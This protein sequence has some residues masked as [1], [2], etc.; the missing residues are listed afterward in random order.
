MQSD[1]TNSESGQP[2]ISHM[3]RFPE[4]LRAFLL[5]HAA[6]AAFIFCL[7]MAAVVIL[8]ADSTLSK[9]VGV[10]C[11][12][13][14]LVA[15]RWGIAKWTAVKLRQQRIQS[16]TLRAGDRR[17]H[18]PTIKA[19]NT[20]T[21]DASEVARPTSISTKPSELTMYSSVQ[22]FEK[23]AAAIDT[24]E[25]PESFNSFPSL[26]DVDATPDFSLE[27]TPW[28]GS[29]L[30][31]TNELISQKNEM[32]RGRPVS[33]LTTYRPHMPVDVA[34]SSL[35][36][37]KKGLA[38]ETGNSLHGADALTP[39]SKSGMPVSRSTITPAQASSV[40][41]LL[42]QVANTGE[43]I[44]VTYAHG[45]RQGEPR[46]LAVVAIVNGGESITV[47]ESGY[48]DEKTYVVHRIMEVRTQDGTKASNPQTIAKFEEYNRSRLENERRRQDLIDTCYW[49]ST[50]KLKACRFDV[51]KVGSGYML[52]NKDTYQST[53]IQARNLETAR[54]AAY[55]VGLML[56]ESKGLW[57]DLQGFF[58]D[59]GVYWP[60]WMK[61]QRQAYLDG[62][63]IAK[64]F[65]QQNP[66]R[67]FLGLRLRD[68]CA[69]YA[70][71]PYWVEQDGQYLDWGRIFE[72][73]E[74]DMPTALKCMSNARIDR[75]EYK[76][77]ILGSNGDRQPI[78]L[79]DAE[80]SQ[81]TLASLLKMGLAQKAPPPELS[82]VLGAMRVSQLKLMAKN[83]GIKTTGTAKA[84]LISMCQKSMPQ[85]M[86]QELIVNHSD[87]VRYLLNPP[88][89]L[90]WD[91]FQDF[92]SCYRQM[93]SMLSTW[94]D[95]R[96][97]TSDE[98]MKQLR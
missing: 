41:Q 20:V 11:V 25:L 42:E 75:D 16:A 18:P 43:F 30:V 1:I 90:T 26:P 51:S 24:P 10:V 91:Q 97:V 65:E 23:A 19:S 82:S 31:W 36:T 5:R 70:K 83:L 80:I 48:P 14:P 96:L 33:L 13:L 32:D 21:P 87:L 15:T 93:F 54:R 58:V 68:R 57:W 85:E 60:A 72:A 88:S 12:F 73:G 50:A 98:V 92:K 78:H 69:E 38:V 84:D 6:K 2:P 17:L 86:A 74:F 59:G 89:G 79:P 39:V 22:E 4:K 64:E 9:T 7:T 77:Y 46:E 49:G 8:R 62:L 66:G 27:H 67:T 76:E 55:A 95:K 37:G 34:T 40:L 56:G 45:S 63:R 47:R 3:N 52:W 71:S 35:T 94:T 28:D 81:K 44:T 53:T 61:L 29:P